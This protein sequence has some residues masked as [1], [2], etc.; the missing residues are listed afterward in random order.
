MSVIDDVKQYSDEILEA[1]T[2]RDKSGRGY[3]CPVCGSGSGKNGTG[4]LPVKG[5]PG[6]YHCFAAGC[7]FEHGD[8]LELIAKTYRLTETAQQ[9]EKAGEL[10]HRDFSNK[11]QWYNEKK[12]YTDSGKDVK[13]MV[14]NDDKN[15]DDKNTGLNQDNL[16][17]QQ[18]IRAFMEAAAAALPESTAALQYLEGR[19]ISQ[20]TAEHYKIGYVSHYG[21]GM[22]TAAVII[23]T[24]PLSYTARSIETDDSSRKV[25]KKKAGDKAGIFGIGIMRNPPPVAFIVEGEFDKLAVNEAGF[26]AIA[27]GGGTS[28]RELV[29]ALQRNGTPPTTFYILPDHDTHPDGTPDPEKGMKAGAEL[30]AMMKEAGLKA[31]LLDVYMESAWPQNYKDCSEFLTHKKDWFVKTL[32][33]LKSDVEEVELERVS[34]YMQDFV[35]QIAGNTPPIPTGYKK[36]DS[37]L[38]GGLHPGLIVVGAISSL[39]KTTFCLN[40]A[41]MLATAGQNVLFYS[42]EM[43]KFELISKIVSRRTAL[44]CL[45]DGLAMN[46]A[47]TNLGVS[48]FKR[49]KADEAA[50]IKG[51]SPEEK[52]LI[53]DCM[54]DFSFK[55]AQH[56]FI[57][58]GMQNIG[59]DKIRQDIQKHL[60]YT[61][62]APVVV[63]DYTQIL[64]SP[65]P[66]LTDKQKT[67]ENVVELKRISRDFETPV[68]CVSS[69]NR[70]NYREPVSMAAFKES[71]AIEYTSDVLIG[72]QYMGM[73]YEEGD[74]D[75]KRTEKIRGIFQ[76]NEQ[77]ARQGKAIPIQCKILKNRSGGKSDSIFNYF[78]M[79]NL[80]LENN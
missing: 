2:E 6:Y 66:H 55:A 42:L 63:V 49:Y 18:E 45:Q 51:Y 53:F 43:S 79:F 15:A 25:R 33:R 69:F 61:G 76:E 50:G 10:I 48:D 80:Y 73:D 35:Q 57:K 46:N 17:E 5:K 64:K 11:N 37:I 24:G 28:K 9:I 7:D 65:D 23:P 21:D 38:E 16:K 1:M 74:T 58:E 3:I 27:T 44:K 4:L 62:A 67:D 54:E 20:S 52:Q 22:N 19:G 30:L 39:G 75:K 59:T 78:P 47:K 29:E 72:L 56:L 40:I 14:Q 26:P 70:D 71:G 8:I 34:G 32:N 60:F 68:I 41:D 13:N 12:T 36:L 77:A 31:L